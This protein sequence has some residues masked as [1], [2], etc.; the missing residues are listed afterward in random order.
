MILQ[1][2]IMHLNNF[3]NQQEVLDKSIKSL[4][5]Q[6]HQANVDREKLELTAKRF[7]KVNI[8][9]STTDY[10]NKIVV[11]DNYLQASYDRIF[12]LE[13]QFKQGPGKK[14]Y[15]QENDAA[16]GNNALRIAKKKT[17]AMKKLYMDLEGQLRIMGLEENTMD[18][19]LEDEKDKA[20]QDIFGGEG[21][22]K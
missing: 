18:F 9:P 10:Q 5:Q 7:K 16:T 11:M 13:M 21:A 22:E 17:A 15:T 8:L 12:E 14:D 4:D 19:A 3:P 1:K 2:K 20:N 6:I